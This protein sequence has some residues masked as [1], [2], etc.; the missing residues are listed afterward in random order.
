MVYVL[1]EDIV[2]RQCLSRLFHA[3]NLAVRCFTS[4]KDFIERSRHKGS[5]CLVVEPSLR[6]MDGFELQEILADS[7]DQ[8]VFLTE[9]ADVSMCARAMK[10][11]AVD[12]LT[13]PAEWATILDAVNRGLARSEAIL[14]AKVA[15]SEAQAK[16]ASL[17]S[18][19]SAVMH[20][21]IAG[22]LN[23]QIAAELCIAVK[24]TKVHRGRVMEKLGVTSVANLVRLVQKAGVTASAMHQTREHALL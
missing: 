15:R 3:A 20:W 13:K 12:F 21:V 19:E 9:H 14:S 8:F 2:T 1:D 4:A 5:C 6:G 17:T 7:A 11:G 24:T 23:K 10:A 22:K 18:R 16:F